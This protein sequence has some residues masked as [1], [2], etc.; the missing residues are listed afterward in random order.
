MLQRVEKFCTKL[1]SESECSSLP[2]HNLVHTQ[3]VVNHIKLISNELGLKIEETEPILIAACFH[4]TGHSEA[5]QG[6]EDV[7]K[8]LAKAFWKKVERDVLTETE[9]RSIIEKELPLKR[10]DQVRDIFVF[11]CFTGLAYVDV[12]RL[13]KNHIVFGMDGN[14]WIKINRSKTDSRSTIPLLPAAE[15]IIS[16]YADHPITVQNGLL[17]PV[18]SNQRTNAYLKEIAD[19]CD[20]EKHLTFHFSQTYFR[21]DCYSSEWDTH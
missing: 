7:S 2:F 13:S 17:L 12:R 3:E 5:Y 1:L 18:I 11:C 16:K 10:L 19:S 14:R 9:L 4:D 6:H 15:E 8:R 21:N 20:I